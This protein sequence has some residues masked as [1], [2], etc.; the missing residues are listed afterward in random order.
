[1]DLKPIGSLPATENI[2]SEYKQ[3]AFHS[4]TLFIIVAACISIAKENDLFS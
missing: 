2:S 1:M 4:T 3:N